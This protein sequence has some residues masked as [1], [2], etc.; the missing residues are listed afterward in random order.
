LHAS[1]SFLNHNPKILLNDNQFVDELLTAGERGGRQASRLLKASVMEYLRTKHPEVPANVKVTVRV[2]ANLK[3]LARAYCDAQ[4]IGNPTELGIFVNGFNM[5]DALCD[6][7]NAGDGKECADEKLKGRTHRKGNQ[8]Y[9]HKAYD[10][11][12]VP[13]EL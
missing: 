9:K 5:E 11:S 6:L 2:Y 10:H 13:V 8:T 3:G 12:C 4:V 1:E 7:V